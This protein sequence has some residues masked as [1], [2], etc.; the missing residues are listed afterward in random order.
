MTES[1]NHSLTDNQN[2]K[3]IDSLKNEIASL[4]SN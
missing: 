4:K 3:D 1:H 2:E